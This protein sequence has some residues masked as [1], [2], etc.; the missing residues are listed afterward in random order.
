MPL[1]CDKT[2]GVVGG[3]LA[4][5]AINAAAG[6]VVG[7]VGSS[8]LSIQHD[9]YDILLATKAGAAGGGLLSLALLGLASCAGCISGLEKEGSST[10]FY[11]FGALVLVDLI[12][13][14]V[15]GAAGYKTIDRGDSQ[16][17]YD[18]ALASTAAGEAAVLAVIALG[19]LGYGVM[20]N[21]RTSELSHLTIF[22]R[23]RGHSTVARAPAI[24]D[25]PKENEIK[26]AELTTVTATSMI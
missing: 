6:A 2:L 26:S 23:A 18:Q 16:M 24:T 13:I 8:L 10:S 14:A 12:F 1:N 4:F 11:V 21:I 25:Q 7:A 9:D 17:N 19:I 3:V 20:D 22:S 15:S 5:P